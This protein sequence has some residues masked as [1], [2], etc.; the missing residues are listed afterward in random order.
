MR[1]AAVAAMLLTTA[2]PVFAQGVE[3]LRDAL[4]KMPE[5]V[6][7]NPAPTQFNFVDM[8]TLHT[9]GDGRT[10]GVKVLLRA[11]VGGGL[12]AFNALNVS[13]P[14]AWSERAKIDIKD[15]SYLAGFGEPPMTVTIWGLADEAAAGALIEALEAD[16]F[17]PMENGIIGNGT[18]MTPNLQRRDP[19]NP[20]RT[21]VG[22]ATFAAAKGN[23]II[24][25]TSPDAVANLLG[26]GPTAA[27]NQIV[28]VALDGLAAA[29]GDDLLVQAMVISPAFGLG[30]I[31]PSIMLTPGAD[32]DALREELE[33]EMEAGSK[34]IP[35]YFGGVI[36]D[37]DGD[38]SGALVALTYPDCDVAGSA[39]EQMAQRWAE[40][41]PE[42][43]QGDVTTSA[44][45]GADGL[46]A[47]TLK[48]V[49][50]AGEGADN[51][52]FRNL[53]DAYLRRSF[54]VLQI[55]EG[56]EA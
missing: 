40:L 34:G 29:M 42:A 11:V 24:H 39:A 45:A 8:A 3:P 27:D 14:D 49:N 48:V 53:F 21:V 20:W 41:M 50:D 23:G 37:V 56:P 54:T 25:A 16:D 44:V 15:V 30:A 31:D 6:L 46:C 55:G 9:L 7:T 1:L 18:P 51:V 19:I 13:G 35:P 32:M 33:A 43:A 10:L 36:A 22:A 47:A 52:V 38:K 26:D 2:S 28:D 12:P 5:M 17:D 4:S